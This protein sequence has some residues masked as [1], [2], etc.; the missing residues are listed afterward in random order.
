MDLDS[1]LLDV[2]AF[3]HKVDVVLV[4]PIQGGNV[5]ATARAMKN[6]GLESLT[7]VGGIQENPDHARWM[8]PGAQDVLDAARHV[9]DVLSAVEGCTLVLGTTARGRHLRW[10]IWDLE[11]TARQVLEHPGRVAILFGQEDKGLSNE[12]LQVCHALCTIHTDRHASLNLAQAVLLVAH[13]IFEE[14]R[15][16]GY[17]PEVHVAQSR[18]G[19]RVHLRDPQ[20]PVE[21]A[22]DQPADAAMVKRAADRA[23]EVLSCTSYLNGRSS[24]QVGLTLYHLLQRSSP[25]IREVEIVLG[26]LS[27]VL[28]RLQHPDDPE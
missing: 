1:P 7:V 15:R 26:M 18:R 2:T 6:M 14:A 27:K 24:E 19:H 22:K 3:A 20:P 23:L 11:T 17:E 28:F 25:T 10:P 4:R 9:G 8:A 13:G 12:D 21:T 5:G 16:R